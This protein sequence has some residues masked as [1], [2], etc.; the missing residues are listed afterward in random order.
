MKTILM[1]TVL[2][3]I[4]LLILFNAPVVSAEIWSFAVTGDGRTDTSTGTDSSGINSRIFTNLLHAIAT[5]NT[6]PQLLLFSGDFVAG[7]NKSLV[8]SLAQQ[9]ENWKKMIH[10]ELTDIPTY[11][12]R[13]NHETYGDTDGRIWLAAFKPLLDR[14]RVSYLSGE[15][16]FSYYFSPAGHP[17]AAIIALDQYQPARA[18]R[19]NLKEFE[20]TLTT[21]KTRQIR[22]IFVVAHEM[23]FTC[24]RHPDSDNMACFPEERNRFLELLKNYRCE[25]FFAGHDH[26]YDWMTI[27]SPDWPTNYVLNQIVAGTAGAPFYGD[28]GYFG[29]HG[30][31]ELKRL[32]HQQNTHGY[33]QV[34]VDD[35]ANKVTVTFK[36]VTL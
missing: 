14:Q 32:E 22:H 27:K 28:K 35:A 31:F 9:F 15:A 18:H 16:G 5:D 36:P 1:G 20:K 13:G 3:L 10:A 33:L 34:L 19:V 23:A 11:V 21:L 17:E 4:R 6:H 30:N 29:N 7:E 24:T 12:V 26:A 25:Y 2:T 8:T